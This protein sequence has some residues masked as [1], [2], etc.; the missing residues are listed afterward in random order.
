MVDVSCE[1]GTGGALT[2]TAFYHS[3]RFDDAPAW[4]DSTSKWLGAEPAY[5]VVESLSGFSL[6]PLLRIHDLGLEFM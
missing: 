4:P 2:H 6:G 3:R 5:E 1:S